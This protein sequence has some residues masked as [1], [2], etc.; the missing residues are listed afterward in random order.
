MSFKD[1]ALALADDLYAYACHLSGSR[2]EAEELVQDAYARAL[3]ARRRFAPGS[4]LKAWMM[5]ILQNAFF[6]DR[7]RQARNVIE[8][9][10][11]DAPA[12]GDVPRALTAFDVERALAEL[13]PDHRNIILLDMN[14]L[15]ESEAAE[16]LGVPAGT[17]KSRL[18]RARAA[19]RVRLAAYGR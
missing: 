1:D 8:L 18:S 7:R 11:A 14:G 15:T 19:L 12:D 5:R 16:L 13:P 9:R 10:P 17:V 2:Q 6:D 4:S 3:A